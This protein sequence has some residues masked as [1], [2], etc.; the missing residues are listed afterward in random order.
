MSSEDED[1]QIRRLWLDP[2]F[3]GSFSGIVTF[4]K[5]LEAKNIMVSQKRLKNILSY[6]PEYV[7]SSQQ[8]KKFSRR[9]YWNH[10]CE[11]DTFTYIFNNWQQYFFTD[12]KKHSRLTW[13]K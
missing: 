2:D 7:Q 9:K 6:I 1:N 13:Q 10:G 5:N 3:P 12:G 4:Q 11:I 8:K